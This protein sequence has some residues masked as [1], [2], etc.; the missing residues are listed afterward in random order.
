MPAMH[1][2][3]SHNLES[4]T[5]RRSLDALMA[6]IRDDYRGVIDDLTGDWE[7]D[8]LHV[9]FTA[10]GHKVNSDVHVGHNVLEWNGYIPTSASIVRAKLQ[11]TIEMKLSEM[12]RLGSRRAAA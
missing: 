8:T 12:L 2:E 1:S 6:A 11:R 7:G 4:V 5:V 3:F 9:T 10:Y